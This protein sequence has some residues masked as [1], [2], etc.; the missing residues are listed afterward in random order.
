MRARWPSALSSGRFYG[1]ASDPYWAYVRLLVGYDGTVGGNTFID[2]SPIG[3]TLTAVGG[4][5]I[6][7]TAQTGF[8]Q[9]GAT[10]GDSL[11]IEASGSA[12]NLDSD[13]FTLETWVYATGTITNDGILGR[14]GFGSAEHWG[15]RIN[16]SNVPTFT[17]GSAPVAVSTTSTIANS[18]V[19]WYFITVERVS[20]TTYIALNGVVEASIGTAWTATSNTQDG[21]I[22]FFSGFAK[23]AGLIDE[24]RLTVGVARYGGSNHAVP[25]EPFP[26]G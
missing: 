20:G 13:D 19:T 5:D 17:G 10:N 21:T 23:F 24:T 18:S 6:D 9:S 4:F 11:T 2:E 12:L 1:S 3:H 14:A 25:T 15:L 26:R 7:A 22:G 8:G 16:S